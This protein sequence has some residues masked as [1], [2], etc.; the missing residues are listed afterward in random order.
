MGENTLTQHSQGRDDWVWIGDTGEAYTETNSRSCERGNA[1]AG[2]GLNIA[3]R[4]GYWH[5]ES[6]GPSHPGMG[7]GGVRGRIHFARVY[8]IPE[9]FGLLGRQ[10]YVYLDHS[11]V[12][13][14]HKFELRVWKNLGGGATKLKADG[15]KY[16]N[17]AG[18]DNGMMDYVW[19]LSTGQMTLYKNRGMT[20]VIN[21]GKSFWDAAAVIWDPATWG[22][23]L[24]RRDLHLVDWDGDG[25]CDIVWVDPD[26]QN[27]PQLWRNLYK[28]TGKWDW[29]HIANPAPD[30]YCSETRGVGIFDLP[31]KFADI[32]GNGRGDYLC[33]EKDGRT[34]GFIH[35]SDDTWEYIDQFKYSEQKDRANLHWADVNGDG[36]ADLIWADKFNGDGWVWWNNGRK[37]VDG[38]RYEWVPAGP[39]YMGNRAGNCMHYP[40]LQGDSRADM[41]ALMYTFTNQAETWFNEC[42]GDAKG[43]DPGGI[44]DPD[45]PVQP[46]ISEITEPTGPWSSLSCSASCPA[47]LV[48]ECP[49]GCITN[50]LASGYCQW[51]GVDTNEAW[52]ASIG[53]F[54]AYRAGGK[55]HDQTKQFSEIISQSINGRQIH[56]WLFPKALTAHLYL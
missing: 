43:D 56:N 32:S 30:L 46:N 9:N 23:E 53:Y 35:N 10:D 15:D 22:A 39:R 3:W 41:H 45:L 19:T 11:K 21:G 26:N 33:M 2:D 44:S 36:K 40:D 12:G 27:K 16:C 54:D 55:D 7:I 8:G 28:S 38:S 25:A 47:D 14:K 17:M 34:W 5:S 6:S 13:D 50:H 1:G 18:H 24:D 29:E 37:D 51:N 42:A 4:R 49:D 20:N 31:V 48:A 52:D